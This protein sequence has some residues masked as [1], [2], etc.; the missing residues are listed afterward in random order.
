MTIPAF[1]PGYPPNG[2]SLGQTKVQIRDNL[3]GTFQ[4]LGVDHVNNNGIPGSNPQGYHTVIHQV[5]QSANPATISGVNQLFSKIAA[6]PSGDTQLF[7]RTGNG[8]VSQLTGNH[9][10]ANGFAWFSGILVQWG[11]VSSITNGMVSFN[12]NPSNYNFPNSCFIVET[13][14]YWVGASAPNGAAGV[15]VKN[16]STTDF[17]WVFNTNSGAYTGGGFYWIAIGN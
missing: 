6:I 14:P 2:F 7:S 11:V 1:V 17:T 16:I 13:Q 9:G 15:S 5:T 12:N 10:A 3:D 8:G 4:T